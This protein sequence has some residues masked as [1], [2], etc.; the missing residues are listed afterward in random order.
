M[1]LHMDIVLF[2][3]E[4]G[5]LMLMVART[6]FLTVHHSF[7]LLFI[8]LTFLKTHITSCSTVAGNMLGTK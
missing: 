5:D 8:V 1:V 7:M 4:R 2:Y 6:E 3:V